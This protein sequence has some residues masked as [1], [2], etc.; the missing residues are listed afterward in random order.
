VGFSFGG[1]L[2]LEVPGGLVIDPAEPFDFDGVHEEESSLITA[3]CQACIGAGLAVAA[4]FLVTGDPIEGGDGGGKGDLSG[5]DDSG[6]DFGE[7][8]D[9]VLA[10]TAEEFEAFALGG[11][12]DAPAVGGDD[13]GGNGDG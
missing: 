3:V 6:D 7:F 12:A 2:L 5:E 1:E 13:E 4:V 9:L 11:E 8:I 10:V